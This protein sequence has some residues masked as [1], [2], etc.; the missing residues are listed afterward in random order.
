MR[1]VGAANHRPPPCMDEHTKA[2]AAGAA[3][4][5]V[6]RTVPSQRH[7]AIPGP[8][9]EVD[10]RAGWQLGAASAAAV[11]HDLQRWGGGRAPAS[12]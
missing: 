4:L 9:P 3:E 6:A 7:F 8:G 5:T 10:G 2:R 12:G 11:Q 1:R